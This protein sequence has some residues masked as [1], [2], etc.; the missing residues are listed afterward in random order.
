MTKIEEIKELIEKAIELKEQGWH[1]YYLGKL[2]VAVDNLDLKTEKDKLK[3]QY[4]DELISHSGDV[5]K[6]N[7]IMTKYRK[8]VMS[9]K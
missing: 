5:K 2:S 9:N 1:N 3:I 7:S 4:F 6:L 8:L